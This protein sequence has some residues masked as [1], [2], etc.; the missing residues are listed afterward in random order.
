MSR[1]TIVYISGNH[2]YLDLKG[3]RKAIMDYGQANG[4]GEMKSEMYSEEVVPGPVLE[5]CLNRAASGAAFVVNSLAAFGVRPSEQRERIITLLGKGV[6]IHVL[7]LG[8]I[9]SFLHILKACW[10]VGLELEREMNQLRLDYDA[11]ERGLAEEKQKFEDR[12]V[13]RMSDV[14]GHG[15][16][17]LFY[18]NGGSADATPTPDAK[19]G[20]EWKP[21][22][23]TKWVG[24]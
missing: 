23:E 6:D 21:D 14:M 17:K 1:Q 10:T 11:H 20:E 22:V 7:G 18:A 3:F 2:E 4:L 12:L 16:V 13:S 9:D 24:Q 8:R 5:E 19:V 15:A